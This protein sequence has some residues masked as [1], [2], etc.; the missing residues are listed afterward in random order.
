MHLAE[1]DYRLW[2]STIAGLSPVRL[3]ELVKNFGS[4]EKIF[5]ADF[6]QFEEVKLK[7]EV[8]EKIINSNKDIFK[9]KKSLVDKGVWYKVLGDKGFPEI[10]N[11]FDDLPFIIFGLG[12]EMALSGS[13]F[14]SVVGSRKMTDYGKAQVRVMLRELLGDKRVTIVSGMA[15]GVDAESHWAAINAGA[16]TIAVL[17]S[18]VD[19]C[20]P[21]QNQVLYRKIIESGNSAV[22]SEYFPGTRPFPGAFPVRNRIIAALS[23]A[24]FVVEA[25]LKSGTLITAREALNYGKGLGVLPARVDMPNSLGALGLIKEGADV[26]LNTNDLRSLIGL[27]ISEGYTNDLESS[28]IV[29]L[30]SEG[31]KHLDEIALI[32]ELDRRLLIVKVEELVETG[33][34]ADL[35][36]G[37]YSR[38]V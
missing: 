15:R 33:R 21:A 38:I 17:G 1:R 23:K 36:A 6:K 29:N 11:N 25:G 28:I 35:G 9:I 30:L 24:T 14:L 26:I 16:G 19:I 20:Y 10:F 37:Y 2:L 3:R 18:G 12:S 32:S 34:L 8:A 31:P 27:P 7:R 22:I 4:A 13:Y 5:A